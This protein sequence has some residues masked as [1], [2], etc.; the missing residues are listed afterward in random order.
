MRFLGLC[1]AAL[2]SLVVPPAHAQMVSHQTGTTYTFQP[3]DCDGAGVKA[4]TFSN[5]AGV[6]VTLPQ[7]GANNH[8]LGG[9]TIQA[10]NLGAGTVTITPATSTINGVSSLSLTTG[11]SARIVNDAAGAATGNYYALLGAASGSGASIPTA[12]VL[13]GA[14]GSYVPLNLGTNLSITSGVLNAAGGGGGSPAGSTGNVQI[15]GG[16]GTFGALATTGSGAVAL[17]TSPTIASPTLTG[18]TTT[19]GITD[20]VGITAPKLNGWGPLFGLTFTAPTIVSAGTGYVNGN[21]LTLVDGCAT[22]GTLAVTANAG[23]AISIATVAL[24]GACASLPTGTLSVTGGTGAG[25][26]FNVKYSALASGILSA[27]NNVGGN[28]F[29]A[30][31]PAAGFA[32][33]ENVLSGNNAGSQLT[34]TSHSNTITGI[35]AGGGAGGTPFVGSLITAYGND[36]CRNLADTMIGIDC[37]GAGALRNQALATSGATVVGNGAAYNENANTAPVNLAVFGPAACQGLAGSAAFHDVTCVGVKNGFQLTTATFSTI[38]GEKTAPT[39]FASG[40]GVLLIGSGYGFVDTPAAGTSHYINIENIFTATN[41]ATP[42]A[43]ASTIAGSLNV[44]GAIT[45]NGSPIA[46]SNLLFGVADTSGGTPAT[47]GTGNAVGDQLTLA[48]GCA[49][50]A[51]LTVGA[52]SSGGVIR[53]I[54]AN[55]GSCLA[56]PTNPVAVTSTT[57]TGT[58]ATFNLAY[59]TLSGGVGYASVGV[60]NNNIFLNSGPTL[61][62]SGLGSSLVGV[63]NGAKL[64]GAANSITGLGY[65]GCGGANAST[66]TPTLV[67]C[68]GYTVGNNI[69]SAATRDVLISAGGINSVISGTDNIVINAGRGGAALTSGIQNALLGGGDI[70]TSGGGNLIAGFNSNATGATI[71]DAVILGGTGAG[72]GNGARG[73]GQSVVIGARAGNG[74]LTGL[75]NFIGG[76]SVAPTNCTSGT[77]DIILGTSNAV[78]CLVSGGSNEINIQNVWTATGTNVP[79]TSITTIAGKAL[80]ANTLGFTGAAPAVSACGTSPSID[81]NASNNSGTVTVGTVAAASCTVTFAASGYTTWNHCR[82][83]AQS[84]TAAFGYTYTKTALTVTATSLIGEVFDYSCDGS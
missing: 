45:Q 38:I 25:A 20:S 71:T 69:T 55:R 51:V 84:A 18:T 16:S 53:Y 14:S 34:G 44:V 8:F 83:T 50:S 79:S 60:N 12:Q 36:A 42:S 74:S 68:I 43:S 75:N 77:G 4:I 48:D 29:I 39:N 80:V 32:G 17:A 26:T 49:T 22:H 81:G 57:G 30:T 1:L 73:G 23:G 19:A 5:S 65:Q 61:G 15:N 82:V 27:P 28:T 33:Q 63:G 54:V 59:G 64:I 35:S 31:L 3:A 66:I 56:V 21:V 41:T 13:G 46:S 58:G 70:I 7:A 62:Y 78:D 6:A 52:V 72:G 24:P 10:T 47:A 67:T 11:Q 2:M 40:T 76:F 37:I 9:C